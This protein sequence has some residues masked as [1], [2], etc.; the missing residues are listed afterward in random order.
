MSV[1]PSTPEAAE[2]W[3]KH[4]IAELKRKHKAEIE[5]MNRSKRLYHQGKSAFTESELT[6]QSND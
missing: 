6:P 4:L 1:I 5:L 3:L 2:K